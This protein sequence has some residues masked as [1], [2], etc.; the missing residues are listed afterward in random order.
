MEEDKVEKPQDS[1]ENVVTTNTVSTKR[2]REHDILVEQD[3]GD[4][5]WLTDTFKMK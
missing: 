1:H 3:I 2:G 5:S 4:F